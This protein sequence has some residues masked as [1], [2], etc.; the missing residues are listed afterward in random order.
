MN[1]YHISDLERLTGIKAHTIRIWERRY[2]LITPHR[3]ATN[4]RYYDD[5]QV[6]KLL[7][8]STLL[9]QGMKISHLS[10]LSDKQLNSHM[11]ELARVAPDDVIII[12][13]INDLT[14]SMLSFNEA[15]FEK[16]FSS[17]VVRFGIYEAMVKVIY[18][19]LKKTGLMW[20]SNDAM[21]V[22]EHF[23]TAIIRRKLISA[24]D[25]LPAPSKKTRSFVL[26]LPT[27]EWHETGLLLSDYLIRSKGY[28]TIYLGQ[29]VP[30]SNLQDVITNTRPTHLLT[31]YIARQD[32][33]KLHNEMYQLASRNKECEVL[34]GG[35][36]QL[37]N[38]VKKA[39]NITH[40]QSPVDLLNVLK[41]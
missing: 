22:Q 7:K 16:T 25:G 27:E 1:S 18:P 5:E 19:F 14:A 35:T 20:S 15:A 8:V 26:F 17:S 40:L 32:A 38:S 39:K 4:I 6:K 34:I 13:F 36:L 41:R 24:I 31:L 23:A 37:I 30:I 29:N 11:L 21:P 2:K 10:E 3:T 9:E 33:E 28:K 12:N